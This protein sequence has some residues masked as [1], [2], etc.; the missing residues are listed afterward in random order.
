ME[1]KFE[2]TVGILWLVSIL[3]FPA[4]LIAMIWSDNIDLII[5]IAW[6][7]LIVLGVLS[8]FMKAIND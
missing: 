1:E 7:N 5:N 4:L 8:V 2:V 3:I 6:T